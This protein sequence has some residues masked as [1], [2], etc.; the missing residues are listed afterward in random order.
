VMISFALFGFVFGGQVPRAPRG[1]YHAL[2]L[3]L[4]LP[5][6]AETSLFLDPLHFGPSFQPSFAALTAGRWNLFLRLFAF[7]LSTHQGLGL[8]F[9]VMN[10]FYFLSCP[11]P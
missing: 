10:L 6:G 2:V 11:K 5:C 7:S 1:I 8:Y 4:A 9:Y 3:V